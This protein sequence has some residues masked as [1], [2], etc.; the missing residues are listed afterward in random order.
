MLKY[1]VVFLKTNKIFEVDASFF[2][3]KNGYDECYQQKILRMTPDQLLMLISIDQTVKCIYNG[4]GSVMTKTKKPNVVFRTDYKGAWV[5]QAMSEGMSF[6]PWVEKTLNSAC[7]T[8]S[9]PEWLGIFTDSTARQIISSG[10]NSFEALTSHS[11]NLC[12]MGFSESQIEE[13]SEKL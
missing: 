12:A 6:V 4:A 8:E 1:E 11:A 13:I 2:T 3:T 7:K 5:H 9:M 10:I